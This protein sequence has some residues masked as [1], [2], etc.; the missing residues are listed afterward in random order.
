MS[1]KLGLASPMGR[2]YGKKSLLFTDNAAA[3]KRKNALYD[4]SVPVFRPVA[5][6]VR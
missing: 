3:F 2:L 1:C 4:V 5:V 6:L